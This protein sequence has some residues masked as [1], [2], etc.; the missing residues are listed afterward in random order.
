MNPIFNRLPEIWK[1]LDVRISNMVPNLKCQWCGYEVTEDYDAFNCPKCGKVLGGKGFLE[2][3]LSVPTAGFGRI[4]GF[5]QEF[6]RSHNI[7]EIR[8]RFLPLLDPVTGNRWKDAKTRQWNRN[9]SEVSVTRS[10]YKGT[11]LIVKDLA[12]EHGSTFCRIIDMASTCAVWDRQ[13]T[14]TQTDDYFYDSDF[15]HPG[16]FLALMSDSVDLE[17]FQEDFQY[18]Q[19]GGT[20]WYFIVTPSDDYITL[21][22]SPSGI[23]IVD[24]GVGDLS[25]PSLVPSSSW[26]VDPEPLEYS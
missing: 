23:P 10:S 5:I 24:V 22:L 16:V 13:G 17:A 14:Y 12:R 18:I 11:D 9:R 4:E 15:H 6:L 1:D 21:T 8:D 20:K 26:G 19:P 2:R 3:F 25:Y 7:Q